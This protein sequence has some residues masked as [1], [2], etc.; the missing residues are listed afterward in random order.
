MLYSLQ[1]IKFGHP[2]K[3]IMLVLYIKIYLGFS[4]IV[5]GQ[6]IFRESGNNF[7]LPYSAINVSG[8]SEVEGS[9]KYPGYLPADVNLPPFEGKN[10]VKLSWISKQGGDWSA[11]ISVAGSNY[12]N[13]SAADTLEFWVYTRDRT[14]KAALPDIS[15][16]D[17]VFGVE[18]VKYPL[19]AYMDGLKPYGWNRVRVPIKQII[20]DPT[21]TGI[22]FKIIKSINLSQSQADDIRHTVWIDWVNIYAAG[23]SSV[24]PPSSLQSKGYDSHV[25][26]NWPSS[27]GVSG[28][29]IY[30]QNPE[31]DY[32]PVRFE[33]AESSRWLDF[34][35]ITLGGGQFEYYIRILSANHIFSTQGPDAGGT[36]TAMSDEELMD[37]VQFY[38][39]RYFWNGAHPTSGMIREGSNTGDVVTTGGTGFGLMALIVG[40]ER[41]WVSRTAGIQRLN[42]I[43]NFL[44]DADR[45]KGVWPHW[46]NGKTGV[47]VPF[48]T[49]DNGGDLV[50]TSFLVEGLYCVRTYMDTTVAEEKAL[51]DKINTLCDDVDWGWYRKQTGNVL[52][53]HWSPTYNWDMN[54]QIR[55][56]NE[57]MITY[58]LGIAAPVKNIPASLFHTG[59][60]GGNYKNGKSFYGYPLAVGYDWG[61]PMFFAHYSFMGF[62]PHYIEDAYANYFVRNTNHALIQ[63]AYSVN[64]PKGFKGYSADCWG[65]TASQDP[66][67]YLAHEPW[68]NDNGTISPTAALGSMP[69]TPEGGIRALKYFYR[70]Q[71]H[72]VFGSMG[73]YD[74]FNETREW[75]ADEYL[76]IDQGP[77]I[78]MIEN[79]RTGLLWDLFMKNPNIKP[80]LDKIGFKESHVATHESQE[81]FQQTIY[82]N[83]ATDAV[84]I[85]FNNSYPA[86]MEIQLLNEAGQ[87]VLTR[88][89]NEK[90]TAGMVKRIDLKGMPNG[91]Y[92]LTLCG[93]NKVYT[94]NKLIKYN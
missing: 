73:F 67:G 18:S 30:R 75:Y 3:W 81:E 29:V 40:I 91:V 1:K 58:I 77:I 87:T 15:L 57:C 47:V 72:K 27:S 90:T 9:E 78:A 92:F 61:G 33:P 62:N 37:M 52:Y 66:D 2:R 65:L 86:D 19:S 4:A 51:R 23:S 26:L 21:Q 43:I 10:S 13:F 32:M 55:G 17:G 31:G 74:A 14:D 88:K 6:D 20:N 82:P 42:K 69:Y 34:P 70:T 12:V 7:Y 24:S 49:K 84:Y 76:A 89:L 41:G 71:R 68:N 59:W 54:L 5:F 45:F 35:D 16:T 48:S 85:K 63:Q 53:W 94:K 36:L 80:A 64:N 25:E 39:F 56:F 93:Q 46:M 11:S 22:D 83:P 79:H 38:T 44:A 60:A 8:P 28:Y 50:E